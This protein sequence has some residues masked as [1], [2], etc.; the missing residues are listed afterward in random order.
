[1]N[2]SSRKHEP[3]V[4]M[5]DGAGRVVGL[6]PQSFWDKLATHPDVIAAAGCNDLMRELSDQVA[7]T[8]ATKLDS[9]IRKAIES[10]IGPLGEDRAAML[11]LLKGRCE[12]VIQEGQP[13]RYFLDDELI[14]EVDD[15]P[16][17]A[18]LAG[19]VGAEFRYRMVPQGESF[20][21]K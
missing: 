10:R 21:A 18:P 15:S 3:M 4:E 13:D 5:R 8:P 12:R 7:T 17:W 2:D 9:L 6:A 19:H 11:A 14:L 1:M 20:R 16:D